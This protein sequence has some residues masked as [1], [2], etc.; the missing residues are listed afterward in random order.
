M[1]CW[2]RGRSGS[3]PSSGPRRLVRTPVAVHLLP[4]EKENRFLTRAPARTSQRAGALKTSFSLSEGRGWLAPRTFTS[5]RE[6]G[7]GL[8]SRVVRHRPHCIDNLSTNSSG[9]SRTMA[10]GM[11]NNRMQTG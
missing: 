2:R 7:E 3:D 10:F 1:L 9:C 8:L 4:W 11:R 6:S 5:G